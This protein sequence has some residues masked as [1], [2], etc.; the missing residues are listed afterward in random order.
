[1]H[2]RRGGGFGNG[3]H[4]NNASQSHD[5]EMR[6]DHYRPQRPNP[7]FTNEKTP[8]NHSRTQRTYFRDQSHPNSCRPPPPHAPQHHNRYQP[9][10]PNLPPS[11]NNNT[12][13]AKCSCDQRNRYI[14]DI[15]Q[16]ILVMLR[17]LQPDED[18]MDWEYT[19]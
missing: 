18:E 9:Y 15:L 12:T 1:M 19:H 7:P 16:S 13:D 8:Y 3:R 4:N 6:N 17:D 2:P 11:S 14:I 5:T 10:T